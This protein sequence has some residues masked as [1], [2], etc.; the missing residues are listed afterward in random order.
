ME[1]IEQARTRLE[2]ALDRLSSAQRR[3]GESIA[4]LKKEPRRGG[5][6]WEALLRSVDIARKENE[7][8]V[9]REKR[10][11]ERLDGLIGQVAALV[12]GRS[13]GDMPSP[14]GAAPGGR[15]DPG[16]AQKGKL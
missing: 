6:E 9:A 16:A 12:S 2:R 5:A 4:K 14:G 10:L 1:K 7:E 15:T 3:L 13:G 11:R 8:L